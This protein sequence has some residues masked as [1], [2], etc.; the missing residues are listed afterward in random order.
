MK[1]KV[2]G[3]NMRLLVRKDVLDDIKE[4]LGRTADGQIDLTDN[5]EEL[6]EKSSKYIKR[7]FSNGKWHYKYPP[8]YSVAENRTETKKDIAKTTKLIIG[9]KPLLNASE[10]EID[11]ALINLSLY[12]MDGRLKCPALGN[13]SIYITGRTQEHIKETH[14]KRR[15]VPEM[16]HKAKYIPF[17]PEILRHGKICE[18]SSSSKGV[19]YGIIG[20]V[21]YFD[22][23]KNR[24]VIESVEL[25]INYDKDSRKFVFSFSDWEIKKSLFDYRDLID[26]SLACPIVDTE[27]VP[28]TVYS[29]S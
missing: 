24:N 4:Y 1:R 10:S 23:N 29:L 27:T 9:I 21:E 13:N 25:A 26:N 20:Q 18:K 17:I 28:I 6:I 22:E 14:G 12:A 5:D 8:K 19:I 3:R 15:I 2:I 7:W 16:K 11:N